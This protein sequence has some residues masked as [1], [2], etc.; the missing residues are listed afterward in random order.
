MTDSE[1]V[2]ILERLKTALQGEVLRH[3]IPERMALFE[4]LWE[5]LSFNPRYCM[6]AQQAAEVVLTHGASPQEYETAVTELNMIL[7]QAVSEL[8]H[9]LSPP[10]PEALQIKPRD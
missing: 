7:G 8:G 5:A 6:G 10:P 3:E 1:R 9:A 2:S 4:D